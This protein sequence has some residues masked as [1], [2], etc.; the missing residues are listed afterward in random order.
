MTDDEHI[1]T[2]YHLREALRHLDEA[3]AGDLRK[4][5]SVALEEVSTTVSTV[6]RERSADE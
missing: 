4:T 3:Q 5:H 2:E 1:D 6:L